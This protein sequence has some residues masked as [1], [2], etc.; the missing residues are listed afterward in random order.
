MNRKKIKNFFSAGTI[1]VE[2]LIVSALLTL[3][4]PAVYGLFIA[5]TQGDANQLKQTEATRLMREMVEVTRIIREQGWNT[6]ANNGTYYPIQ[7][8]NSWSFQSGEETINEY[9]RSLIIGDVY[10]DVNDLIIENG[11]ELDLSTKKILY[12]VSWDTPF[13]GGEVI[14]TKYFTRY[15]D[16]IAFTH[17]TNTDFS[18]GILTNTTVTAVLDGEVTLSSGTTGTYE[19]APLDANGSSSFAYLSFT[20]FVPNNSSVKM[21]VAVADP[22]NNSCATASYNYVGPNGTDQTYFDP[23]GAIP[24]DGDNS[25]YEN[26]GRCFKYKA[27]FTNVVQTEK[28][29]LRSVTITYTP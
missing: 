9:K 4:V 8:G 29:E 6:F 3:I 21:Q 24:F 22:V 16:T 28:P 25:G 1:L 14:S 23:S 10:R 18:S 11:G 17:S 12:R 15:I 26:P 7:N 5:G 20:T 2:F 19:S 27:F 13:P